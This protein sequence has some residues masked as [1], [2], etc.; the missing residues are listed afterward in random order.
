MWRSRTFIYG[1]GEAGFASDYRTYHLIG[2]ARSQAIAE[3]L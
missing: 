1:K 2:G 3:L